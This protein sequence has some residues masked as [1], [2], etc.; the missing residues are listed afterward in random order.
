LVDVL[1]VLKIAFFVLAWN[2]FVSVPLVDVII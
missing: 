1:F 2:H